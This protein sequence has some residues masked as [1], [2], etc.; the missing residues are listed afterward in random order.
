IQNFL[1]IQQQLMSGLLLTKA[2]GLLAVS[3]QVSQV[4][5]LTGSFGTISSKAELKR[6]LILFDRRPGTPTWTIYSAAKSHVAGRWVSLQGGMKMILQV[7]SSR[8]TTMVS[9]VG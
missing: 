1:T 2:I 5:V 3:P 8:T 6:I 9:L 7:A 4:I